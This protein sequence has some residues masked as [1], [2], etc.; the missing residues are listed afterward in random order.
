MP[1]I[2]KSGYLGNTNLGLYALIT[3]EW[4]LFP[5][6][7]KKRDLFGV[8]SKIEVTI[9]NTNLIGLF[10]AGNTNGVVLPSLIKERELAKMKEIVNYTTIDSELTAL[11]NLI[12]CNDQ[13]AIIGPHLKEHRQAIEET[14]AVPTTV[15]TLNE[16]NIVGSSGVATNNGALLHR[17]SSDQELEVVESTLAVEAD[18][19]TV[20]FGSP[21]VGTSILA[22]S[23][24]VL[25]G[26]ETKGPEL[27]RI[28]SAL[29]K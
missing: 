13:G 7:F 25:V 21:Y 12:L 23:Q 27:G 8:D 20:N 24:G 15:G 9:A 14:L 29:G 5:P 18:I 4:G 28:Y 26:N 10:C 3:E 11:G 22:N 19:G 1:E 16:L 2:D 6:E 17:N